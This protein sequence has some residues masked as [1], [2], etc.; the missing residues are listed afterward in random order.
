MQPDTPVDP[1]ADMTA[2]WPAWHIWRGRDGRGAEKG[3]YATLRRK[4]TAGQAVVGPADSLNA[5]TADALRGLLAQQK[6][7]EDR[8][9][10]GPA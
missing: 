4:L 2:A 9:V 1:I 6:V 3:W 10:G 5:A 8:L 7:I